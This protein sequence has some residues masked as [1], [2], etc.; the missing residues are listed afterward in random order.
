[1][2]GIDRVGWLARWARRKAAARQTITPVVAASAVA[3]PG[4]LPADRTAPPSPA[5]SAPTAPAAGPAPSPS[6]EV[7]VE[8]LPPVDSL[9]YESDFSP[10]LRPGVPEALREKALRKLWRS[11]PVLANLDGLNDYDE[12]YSTVGII[13]ETVETLFRIGRGMA[14]PEAVP[15]GASPQAIAT[16]HPAAAPTEGVS[17]APQAEPPAED[18]SSADDKPA[19]RAT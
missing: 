16:S 17:S 2:K 14:E 5:A 12:D 13:E 19:G 8:D 11:N 3:A 6:A 7:R 10:Y 4:T 9:T 18:G 1:M 15:E